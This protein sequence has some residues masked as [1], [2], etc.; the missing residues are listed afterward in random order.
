MR[1][2]FLVLLLSTAPMRADT[3]SRE[4]ASFFE[5]SIRPLLHR[6]CLSCHSYDAKK[7]RG[8]LLLDSRDALLAGGDTGPA[9]VPGQPAK[10]L[11]V[12]AVRH[13]H[14]TVQMPPEGKLP[15]RDVALL[16]EWVQ[17]GVPYPG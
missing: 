6:R 11:L 7:R 4:D 12:Q 5:K 13:E 17:R 3:P 8:G 16:E 15:P 2:A 9:V 14:A 10:S 1:P